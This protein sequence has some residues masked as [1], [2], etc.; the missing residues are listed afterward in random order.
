MMEL[1]K[2][3]RRNSLHTLVLLSCMIALL[4]ALGYS[5]FGP[6]GSLFMLFTTAILILFTPQ[7]SA[8]LTLRFY[9]ARPLP[10]QHLPDLHELIQKL[11]VQAHLKETPLLYLIPS[12][13]PNAFAMQDKNLPLIAL[14]DG[15]F[16]Q[17][18]S[19]EVA[20]I[21][22]HEISHIRNGDLNVMMLADLLSR[23]TAALS[24]AGCL[25]LIIFLPLW[26]I[27][28]IALPWQTLL[29]LLIAPTASMLL[30]FTLSRTREFD[31]DMDAAELTGDP[32]ALASALVKIQRASEP[33]W[34]RFFLPG[35]R[36]TT[37]SLLRT[38]P[39]T[40]ERV[41]RLE[42]I[43]DKSMQKVLLPKESFKLL[44]HNHLIIKPRRWHGFGI[45]Y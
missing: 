14:T 4:L 15:I 28:E 1:Q 17:L 36:Q 26:L 33:W 9:N 29:L 41:E 34:Q 8:W 44:P 2:Y 20:A 11:A 23:T 21:L 27:S 42:S 32:H 18:S 7:T 39:A 40:T 10:Y 13:M 16:R 25:I 31:A 12:S 5:L 22:A 24:H 19:R 3:K 30:Q 43:A 35:K 38:H 6:I 37:P 45:W